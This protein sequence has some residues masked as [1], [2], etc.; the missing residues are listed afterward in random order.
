MQESE[1][2]NDEF[3]GGISGLVAWSSQ[4]KSCFA[5]KIAL[6]SWGLGKDRYTV[7]VTMTVD[8]VGRSD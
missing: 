2:R 1:E 8:D 5:P 6:F 4:G 7:E 3:P